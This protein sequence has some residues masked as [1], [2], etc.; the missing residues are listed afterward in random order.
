MQ[1]ESVELV[2]GFYSAGQMNLLYNTLLPLQHAR[3]LTLNTMKFVSYKHN[4]RGWGRAS[5]GGGGG[6]GGGRKTATA[7]SISIKKKA[8]A[9]SLGPWSL[10]PLSSGPGSSVYSLP[11]SRAL[12]AA[13]TE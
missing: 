9:R 6:G 13:S 2:S 10:G 8:R 1:S 5:L 11:R 7:T 3:G 12:L 4:T